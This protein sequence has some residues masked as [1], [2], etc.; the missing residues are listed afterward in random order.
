MGISI[1]KNFK[2]YHWIKNYSCHV[3]LKK[4]RFQCELLRTPCIYELSNVEVSTETNIYSRY[5]YLVATRDE[6]E[7]QPD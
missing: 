3:I 2:A 7:M 4:T 5:Y 1:K 6:G